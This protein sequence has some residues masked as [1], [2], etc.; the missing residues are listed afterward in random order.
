MYGEKT[1]PL[2]TRAQ[3]RNRTATKKP[4]NAVHSPVFFGQRCF[5]PCP[6]FV[7]NRNPACE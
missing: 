3:L 1:A 2:S 7:A 4:E 6:S 5:A